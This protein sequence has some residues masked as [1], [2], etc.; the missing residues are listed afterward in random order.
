MNVLITS[1]GRRVSLVK[2]FKTELTKTP[3]QGKVFTT[4]LNPKLSAACHVSDQAFA[5][6]RVCSNNYIEQLLTICLE[7]NVKLIIPTIDTELLILAENKQA[8]LNKGVMIVVASPSFVKKCRDKHHIHQFFIDNNIEVAKEYSRD[9]YQ[10]PLFLKP[11]DGSRSIDTYVIKEEKDLS[12][13][14]Y[15]NEKLMFLE[16]LDPEIYDEYTCDLYYDKT[17]HLKCVVPRKR[18]ETRDGEVSK[19][20]TENN[21]IVDFLK[22]R[23]LFIDGA[24]GCLTLQVFKG[25]TNQRIVGIEINPRFGGGFPLTYGSGANYIKW[26][27]DEYLRDKRIEDSFDCW[28][29][30]LLMLRYDKEIF[31]NDFDD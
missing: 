26:I 21:M 23:L 4:D 29:S 27:L 12:S 31:V 14:H 19:G 20:L 13:K 5:V 11:Y 3:Y 10:L 15:D 2:A 16:Y 18:I 6:P 24:I 1:A 25:K 7:N 30:N 28:Q 17:N 22:E 8:F 9:N